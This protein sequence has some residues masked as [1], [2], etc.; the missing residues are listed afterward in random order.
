MVK[1]IG[2]EGIIPRTCRAM[3]GLRTTLKYPTTS[4][5]QNR[6]DD[7]E[8][9]VQSRRVKIRGQGRQQTSQEMVSYVK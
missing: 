1:A 2:A 8:G 3:R 9:M 6:R 4:G 7:L 5:M